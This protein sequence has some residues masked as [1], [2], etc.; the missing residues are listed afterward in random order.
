MSVKIQV[1]VNS[2]TI[3][4]DGL[5]IFNRDNIMIH[6]N[7]IQRSITQESYEYLNNYPFETVNSRD[8][9]SFF[10]YSI[11]SVRGGEI[12]SA[13]LQGDF[14][15][16]KTIILEIVGEFYSSSL[17]QIKISGLTILDIN[18]NSLRTTKRVKNYLSKLDNLEL[19]GDEFI[20]LKTRSYVKPQ[21]LLKK[22]RIFK[23]VKKIPYYNYDDNINPDGQNCFSYFLKNYYNKLGNKTKEEFN[24]LQGV[25]LQE[26]IDFTNKYKIKCALLN[27]ASRIIYKNNFDRNKNYRNLNA[28][29]TS[30][31]IYPLKRKYNS[32]M[33]RL[34]DRI[35][36]NQ[37]LNK[38]Y[39]MIQKNNKM[40]SCEGMYRFEILSDQE[41]DKIMFAGLKP[42]FFYDDDLTSMRSL[43]YTNKNIYNCKY[44][45]DMNKAF[46]NIAYKIIDPASKYPVF[47]LIDMWKPYK[48]QHINDLSYYVLTKNIT[49][50]LKKY[51]FKNNYT[52]GFIIKILLDNE[53]ISKDDIEYYKKP[54]YE[55]Q[56]ADVLKKLEKLIYNYASKKL[57]KQLDQINDDIIKQ[58]GIDSEFVLYNGILGKCTS[59][60]YEIIYGLDKEDYELLNYNSK[61]ELWEMHPNDDNT[62][63][64]KKRKTI[65]K[66]ASNVS[67]YNHIIQNTN[68]ILLLNILHIKKEFGILPL[69]INTDSITYDREINLI[70]E[71]IKYFKLQT[72]E[73]DI[74]NLQNLPVK[75]KKIFKMAF[76]SHQTY[77]DIENI[78]YNI[79]I[80]QNE[81]FKDNISF[82]GHAGTGKTTK[83]KG[84]KEYNIQ[85]IHYD[86]STT[87][88]NVCALNMS[89]DTKKAKTTYSLF[90]LYDPDLWF[91]HMMRLKNRTLWLDEYSM[92]PKYH[93]NFIILACIKYNCK[94]I[95][96]GDINQIPPVKES[97]N[98]ISPNSVLNKLF[99][100]IEVLKDD[101]RNDKKIIELREFVLNNNK[102]KL[103]NEFKKLN[104]NEDWRKYNRHIV[105]HNE[106]KNY[107]NTEILKYRGYTFKFNYDEE[108]NYKSLDVS[109]GVYLNCR[110]TKKNEHIYRNDIWIVKERFYSTDDEGYLLYNLRTKDETFFQMD[111]MDMFTLGFA[112]TVHSAQGLTIKEPFCIHQITKMIGWEKSIIYTAITRGTAFNNL[113]LFYNNKYGKNN[114]INLPKICSD[115]DEEGFNKGQQLKIH[116]N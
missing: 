84:C 16:L 63:I 11:D 22:Y 116:K 14:N 45:Y 58:S 1:I 43:H 106:V 108:N 105:V 56:W 50:K 35:N 19:V 17:V 10:D 34:D 100:K 99:N 33:P 103:W 5:Q 88:T 107:I 44:E 23:N 66:N 81:K 77:F 79:N 115:E 39:I 38:N 93:Y 76:K 59:E 51:G 9:R 95:A 6:S 71:H 24:K 47:T 72:I 74:D 40:Y 27:V 68:K 61:N 70:D 13:I 52:T 80:L 30:N 26:V 48:K 57:N 96:T 18:Q 2:N 12:I 53:L 69:K 89:D 32:I 31:H 104:C 62:V 60:Q 97:A 25:T 3:N 112:T 7:L 41:I 83:I 64:F 20:N 49:K 101:Y 75:N 78:I 86:I 87:V 28:I 37:F 73:E 15:T 67:I 90:G 98:D 113:K 102:Y 42:S 82:Q 92:V 21:N 94:L 4:S 85:P 54:T 110:A 114:Y 46:F 111:L 91:K 65:F 109:N 36:N 55:V 29:I 8:L